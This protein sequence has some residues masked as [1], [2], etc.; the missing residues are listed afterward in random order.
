[1][2]SH[3][4]RTSNGTLVDEQLIVALAI[5]EIVSCLRAFVDPFERMKY[6][7]PGSW[8]QG[9]SAGEVLVSDT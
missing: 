7:P 3:R 1:M 4:A 5:E 9:E 8:C 6:L 2:S